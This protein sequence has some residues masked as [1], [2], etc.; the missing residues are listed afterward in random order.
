MIA[1]L[2][3]E[4]GKEIQANKPDPPE[5]KEIQANK[6]VPPYWDEGSKGL[7]S[8]KKD[9]HNFNILEETRANK[10]DLKAGASTKI[11]KTNQAQK[12]DESQDYSIDFAS[13]D[14][15]EES[16]Y[17]P[18]LERH[19]PWSY[20]F[21]NDGDDANNLLT[22]GSSSNADSMVFEFGKI[23]PDSK[24]I[25]KSTAKTVVKKQYKRQG[26]SKSKKKPLP[27]PAI[28]KN[29]FGSNKKVVQKDEETE[30]STVAAAEKKVG[31]FSES[32]TNNTSFDE[33]ETAKITSLTEVK[34]L[35]SNPENSKRKSDVGDHELES[36]CDDHSL[37]SQMSDEFSSEE[38]P[39]YR[40]TKRG[41]RCRLRRI[42]TKKGL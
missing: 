40:T 33:V 41:A 25:D 7:S 19:E 12:V 21:D 31:S 17:F 13:D 29:Q 18:L 10:L 5:G 16:G 22:S 23:F 27:I 3:L 26:K 1:S 15:V 38:G 28:V 11:S 37:Q 39:L 34:E 32:K 9:E 42:G 35:D 30:L 14:L 2:T 4:E 6:P 8:L 24:N 36:D 20:P